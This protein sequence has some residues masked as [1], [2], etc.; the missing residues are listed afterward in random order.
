MVMCLDL[1][2]TKKMGLSNG[3]VFGTNLRNVDGI[4]LGLGVG[5]ELGYLDG[6]FGGSNDI[7]LEILLLGGSLGRTYGKLFSTILGNI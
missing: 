3:K 7:K 4:T 2:K 1:M 5:T 6:S